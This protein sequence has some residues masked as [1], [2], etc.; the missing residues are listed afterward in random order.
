MMEEAIIARLLGTSGVAALVG[1]R[2]YPGSVPQGEAMPA[3]VIN[4]ISGGPLYADDGEVGLDNVRIQ[5]DCWGETYSSAKLLAREVRESLSAFSG[6][7]DEVTFP[8]ILLDTIR[9]MREGGGNQ[10][11][12]LFRTNMDFIV[13]SET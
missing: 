1:A 7:V 2:V 10:T 6:T 9:D 8:Y 4:V 11:E 12:Y 5:I 3:V 13:W